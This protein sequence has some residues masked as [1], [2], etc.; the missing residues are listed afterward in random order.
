MGTLA[1]VAGILFSWAGIDMNAA[2]IKELKHPSKQYPVS[3]FFAGILAFIIFAVGTLIIA[4][5]IPAS[6][7]NILDALFVTF[8]DLGAT[9]HAPWLYM[10]FIYANSLVMLAIWIT[11]LAGSSF[12]LG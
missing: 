6:K 11:N 9:I 7:I 5:I 1:L 12:M 3:I 2:H 4:A 10:L 8:H